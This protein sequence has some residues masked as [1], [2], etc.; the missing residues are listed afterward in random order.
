M[1][2]INPL[3]NLIQ[4]LITLN[5]IE[6]AYVE[7]RTN[8]FE[9]IYLHLVVNEE[10]KE[11]FL[12]SISS[13]IDNLSSVVYVRKYKTSMYIK[14]DDFVSAFIL[15]DFDDY[16]VYTHS[17]VLY[18]PNKKLN[19]VKKEVPS[20]ET[21]Y[22]INDIAYNLDRAYNFLKI[23]DNIMALRYLNMVNEK[24]LLFLKTTF[25][26][27]KIYRSYKDLLNSLPKDMKNK[28]LKI[29]SKLKVDSLV[30]CMKMFVVFMD[31]FINKI[32]INV[33]FVVDIDYYMFVKK[34]IFN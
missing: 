4:Q 6:A 17:M 20:D 22:I 7:N 18:D 12:N 15:F 11:V 10:E 16:N 3:N 30:E 33:A 29:V 23:E 21:G 32:S 5:Y 26:P 28:Y 14:F 9:E 8:E 2:E 24:V 19:S 1:K 13:I 27:Q 34:M 31:D 25:E